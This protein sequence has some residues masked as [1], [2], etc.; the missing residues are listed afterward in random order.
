MAFV[1]L[2]IKSHTKVP[3][4]HGASWTE[5]QHPSFLMRGLCLLIV[6]SV[7]KL[8]KHSDHESLCLSLLW[9]KTIERMTN[10]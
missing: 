4:L 3:V 7:P 6:L 8:T 9:Q 2:E 1:K 5:Q 10:L